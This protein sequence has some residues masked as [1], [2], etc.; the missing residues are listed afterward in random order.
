VSSSDETEAGRP[1]SEQRALAELAAVAD[2]LRTAGLWLE[3]LVVP[4]APPRSILAAA[5]S[6]QAD[7]IVMATR[8]GRAAL[9]RWIHGSVADEILRHASVPV[10]LVTPRMKSVWAPT[11]RL[12]ILV[13]L[14]G[15][16]LAEEALRRVDRLAGHIEADVLLLHVLEPSANAGSPGGAE[17]VFVAEGAAGAGQAR[18]YLSRAAA[19]VR[20]SKHQAELLVEVGAAPTVIAAVA[21]ERSVHLIAMATHGHGALARLLLGSVSAAVLDQADVP[22]L[23]MRP[24]QLAGPDGGGAAAREGGVRPT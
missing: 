19:N 7:I 1:P 20:S 10:V 11:E 16:E 2:R 9:D 13:P 24:G 21:R 22:L 17:P 8:R 5:D 4:G 15:S 6:V 18:R 14:D 3:Q 23:L 12:R